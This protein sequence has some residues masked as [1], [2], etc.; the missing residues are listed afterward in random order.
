[1]MR[2][3]RSLPWPAGPASE[4]TTAA[5]STARKR[6]MNSGPKNIAQPPPHPIICGPKAYL[7]ASDGACASAA[8]GTRVKAALTAANIGIRTFWRTP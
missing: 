4:K 2:W 8:A 1:V 6:T 3:H 7:S 5:I